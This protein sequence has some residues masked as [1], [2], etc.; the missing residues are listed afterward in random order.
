MQKALHS[1]TCHLGIL[2]G[3]H[4]SQ[5]SDSDIST[6]ILKHWNKPRKQNGKSESPAPGPQGFGIRLK[7]TVVRV[8]GHL[9]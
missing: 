4:G 6:T 3:H 9:H 7:G 1:P 2:K 5:D 8:L